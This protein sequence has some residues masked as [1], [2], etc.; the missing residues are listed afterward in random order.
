[1]IALSYRWTHQDGTTASQDFKY[2]FSPPFDPYDFQ[3]G[4]CALGEVEK[5]DDGVGFKLHREECASPQKYICQSPSLA[6]MPPMD[7]P[8]MVDMPMPVHD[9]MPV[10]ADMSAD[11]DLPADY[12][13]V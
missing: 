1:M 5:F 2:E 4:S 12:Y 10:M 11:A 6:E 9:E 7:M 3:S 8:P 13:D